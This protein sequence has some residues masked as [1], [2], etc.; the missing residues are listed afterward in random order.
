[1]SRSKELIFNTTII[2]IGRISTQLVSFFLL[3]LYT[4]ILTTEEYGT[5]D[6]FVTIST[7]LIPVITLLMEESMFRFLIDCKNDNEKKEIISQT[8]IY[9][10]VST[11][12]FS[13][14]I[15][16]ISRFITIPYCN[17][18]ILYLIS[19]ILV[20]VRNAL[21]RGLGKIK[22][23]S[24][25]NFITS[26]MNIILNIL[27]IAWLKKGVAGLLLANIIT[28]LIT[29]LII[30]IKL[31]VHK[32]ISIRLYNKNKMK[33]M[34][35]YSVPL[36]PNSVS[37]TIINLSDRLVI[38]SM[39][40]S[41]ENGVYSISN[42]FPNLMN[43]I[44]SF[45]YMAWKESAAK[46]LQDND[47]DKFYNNVYRCLKD[48]MWAIVVGMISVMPFVFNLIIKNDF[49]EAYLYIPILIVSMYFSNISGFYGGIFSAYKDTKIMGSTTIVSAILN[50]VINIALIKFIG[51]WAA[52][53][54]TLISTLVVYLYRKVK[55][56]KY[57]MLE[58][59]KRK[60]ILSWIALFISAIIYYIDNL[61]LRILL[62]IVIILYC[63]IINRAILDTVY[64]FLKAKLF[65]K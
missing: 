50:L 40:G 44:Y 3:P 61:P 10:T 34:I 5:Y 14:I 53:I 38:T 60:F 2:G 54:S 19:S 39:L 6:L 63:I 45:F 23:Y 13:I 30:L 52:A 20:G 49:I 29:S 48:F 57:I 26:L 35:K 27:F 28:N 37:W 1:M 22:L 55:I 43:T 59:D 36:V 15:F 42:K 51:I 12:I 41:A 47:T 46:T 8:V 16:I 56:K 33:E 7:F 25:S 18:F 31:Q 62:L 17:L 64:T 24:V 65:N 32:Y 9:T 4:S 21:T 11:I 58:E